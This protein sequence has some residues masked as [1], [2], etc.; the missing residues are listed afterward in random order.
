[1]AYMSDESGNAQ[2]YVQS[3]PTP[4]G[5]WQV[6]SSG[7]LYPRWNPNGKELFYVA[8]DGKLVS[9]AVRISPAFEAEA[10]QVMFAT[11]LSLDAQRQ[12]YSVSSDGQR[13]LLNTPVEAASSPLTVL[14]NWHALFRK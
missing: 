4:T 13:F 10:P 1:M 12:T 5:K 8:L 14:V 9:V 2:V 3:F 6:S 7:G 11:G